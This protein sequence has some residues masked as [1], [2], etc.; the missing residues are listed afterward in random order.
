MNKEEKNI[1]NNEMKKVIL[2]LLVVLTLVLTLS[3][4]VAVLEGPFWKTFERGER[5]EFCAQNDR[6]CNSGGC[7]YCVTYETNLGCYNSLEFSRCSGAPTPGDDNGSGGSTGPDLVEPSITVHSPIENKI[8]S[9]KRVLLDVELNEKAKI[10]YLVDGPRANWKE[11]CRNGCKN[12]QAELRLED[13]PNKVF[14]RAID[15]SQNVNSTEISFF[16]DSSAP[17]I[18]GTEPRKGYSDG[19]FSLEVMEQNIEKLTLVIQGNEYN[20]NPSVCVDGK[21]GKSCVANVNI[22]NYD[23]QSVEYYFIVKDIAGNVEQS[24][25][26]TVKV[27]VSDPIIED[28][29]VVNDGKYMYLR[30]QIDEPFLDSVEYI[31]LDDPKSKNSQLCRKLVNGMCEGKLK[32]KDG[33]HTLSIMVYDEA[34]NAVGESIELFTD[35][36]KPKIMISEPKKGFANGEFYVEFKEENPEELIL[37]YGTFDNMRSAQVNLNE[38]VDEKRGKGCWIDVDLSS[39]DGEEIQYYFEITDRVGNKDISKAT[40][41][42]VDISDPIINDWSFSSEGLKVNFMFD[43]NENNFDEIVYIDLVDP[44][45][46]ETR[47]CSKL[48]NGVCET[49]KNFREGQHS[50]KIMIYDKAGNSVEV[51][52]EFESSR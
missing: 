5:I 30:V 6:V 43:I 48:N 51:G 33:E 23:G 25:T 9:T 52:A 12:G 19:S 34:G 20:I 15:G 35:V 37:R 26:Q 38:C 24:K 13:G 36:T 22:N 1:R 27:D 44:K 29:E 10:E 45:G 8:Y 50:L 31:D 46:M 2:G 18:L 39:Y 41:L 40:N 17:R 14:V 4:V 28:I 21:R 7:I 16:V 32:L 3:Y 49:R 42:K 47:L 11:I